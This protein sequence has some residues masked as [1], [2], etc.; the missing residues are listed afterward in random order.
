MVIGPQGKNI[1]ALCAE[2]DCELNVEED[3]KCIV[4]GTDQEKL[5]QAIKILEG[6]I[7]NNSAFLRAGS[8]SSPCPR[9][10]VNVTTSH[11]YSV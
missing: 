8:S 2:Y 11:A 5:E 9:S 6:F 1:K 3:G 10:A 7:P 4:S